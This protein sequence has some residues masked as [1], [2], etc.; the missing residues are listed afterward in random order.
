MARCFGRGGAGRSHGVPAPLMGVSFTWLYR[1]C[2]SFIPARTKIGFFRPRGRE[3][4][5]SYQINYCPE[6]IKQGVRRPGMA[7]H[8]STEKHTKGIGDERT[9][10]IVQVLSLR[11]TLIR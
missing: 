9:R 10:T 5:S 2:S 6:G 3:A 4:S 7:K 8:V 1:S 11:S